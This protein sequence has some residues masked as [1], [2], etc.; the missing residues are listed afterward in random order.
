[1]SVS[2]PV[3]NRQAVPILPCVLVDEGE[4]AGQGRGM[5]LLGEESLKRR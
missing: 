1:M 4:E 5:L 3:G 2:G